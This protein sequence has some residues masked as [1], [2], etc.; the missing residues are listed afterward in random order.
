MFLKILG[1]NCSVA[2]SGCGSSEACMSFLQ[3]W[4]Y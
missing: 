2:P 1:G 3:R 4:L